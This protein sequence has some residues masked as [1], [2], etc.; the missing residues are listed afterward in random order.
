M[1]STANAITTKYV[2]RIQILENI[3]LIDIF[4]VEKCKYMKDIE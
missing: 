2:K 4:H 1:Y 3:T